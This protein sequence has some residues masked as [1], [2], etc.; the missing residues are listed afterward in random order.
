MG[1]TFKTTDTLKLIKGGALSRRE[2]FSMMAL[3]SLLSNQNITDCASILANRENRDSCEILARVAIAH[4]E[5]LCT[6]L[7]RLCN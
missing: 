7:D 1:Q 3:Q 2:I 6:E 4:V 5:A